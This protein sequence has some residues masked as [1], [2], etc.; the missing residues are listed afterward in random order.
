MGIITMGLLTLDYEEDGKHYKWDS[1]KGWVN[2]VN[3]NTIGQDYEWERT[4]ER[5]K[6]LRSQSD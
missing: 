2:R 1:E 4:K 6:R 3:G 5:I